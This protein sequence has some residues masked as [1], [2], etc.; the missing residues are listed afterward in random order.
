MLLT[1]DHLQALDTLAGS[2]AAGHTLYTI[3]E[4][5]HT[6]TLFR[7]LELQ[8][9]LTEEL[10]SARG[11]TKAETSSNEEHQRSSLRLNMHGE[12]WLSFAR[13]ARPQLEINGDLAHTM[14]HMHSSYAD[15]H[16]LSMKPEHLALLEAMELLTWSVP[17]G[18]VATLTA[19]GQT[20]Y[21][22]LHK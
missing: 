8:G 13:R 1:T 3:T 7:V 10:L 4:D 22:T 2:E 9:P 5:A 11:F 12:V 18:E 19:L 6:Q 14:L 17:D 16:T 15:M 20:V 21:E